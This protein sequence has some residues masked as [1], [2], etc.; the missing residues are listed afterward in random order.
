MK[1]TTMILAVALLA[2]AVIPGS[3]SATVEMKQ[4]GSWY[5]YG[6][7]RIFRDFPFDGSSKMR[8][9]TITFSA[10]DGTLSDD[11]TAPNPASIG[12]AILT[13]RK[14]AFYLS[15]SSTL[16]INNAYQGYSYRSAYDNYRACAVWTDSPMNGLDYNPPFGGENCYWRS[17]PTYSSSKTYKLVN[18]HGAKKQ[19]GASYNSWYS[20]EECKAG[21]QWS[22][23]CNGWA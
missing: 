1:K 8:I 6:L 9:E 13:D 18:Q 16:Y 22:S 3:A 21:Q 12:W 11:L 20:S 5:F 14:D 17:A 4:D 19:S 15:A 7:G 10:D 23:G 2:M